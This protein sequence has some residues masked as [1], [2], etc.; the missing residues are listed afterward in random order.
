MTHTLTLNFDSTKELL[1]FTAKHLNPQTTI[2]SSAAPADLKVEV[3]AAAKTDDALAPKA[4][5]KA[6]KVKI[7]EP[8]THTD[9]ADN[10]D[11]VVGAR[12]AAETEAAAESKVVAKDETLDP[13]HPEHYKRHVRPI[14]ISLIKH[15]DGDGQARMAKIFDDF[16]VTNATELTAK[17]LPAYLAAVKKD[18]AAVKKDLGEE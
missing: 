16:G 18:L 10:G 12:A 7:E 5:K 3:S 9:L 2:T 14:A 6:T 17:Q 1:E 13:N 11:E 8:T 15:P 4:A